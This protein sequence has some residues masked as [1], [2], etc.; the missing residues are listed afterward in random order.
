MKMKKLLIF[1]IILQ[2]L[3]LTANAQEL[4]IAVVNMETLFQ[5]YEKTKMAEIQ[6]NQQVEIVQEYSRKLYTEV[7]QLRKE[8]ES[9]RDESQNL[10][11]SPAERE[12]R[13]ANAQEK[14]RLLMAK[15]RELSEFNT[16]RQKQLREDYE[17]ICKDLIEEI[18]RIVQQKAVIEGYS[19]ILDQSSLN[20]TVLYF[21]PAVPDLTEST[22][23]ELNRAYRSDASSTSESDASQ[24]S[25]T[26]GREDES[27]QSSNN[28]KVENGEGNNAE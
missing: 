17:K 18:R 24:A 3:A 10:A 6:F 16:T 14:Y 20:P 26:S 22:L 15:D 12:N 25:K 19:L 8:F 11:L 21:S 2:F 1:T 4:K 5:N 7:Q 9:L 13:Q 28:T 27:K 23:E